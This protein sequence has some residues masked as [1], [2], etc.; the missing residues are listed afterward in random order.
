MRSSLQKCRAQ[1]ASARSPPAKPASPNPYASVSER[2]FVRSASLRAERRGRRR[3]DAER[4]RE[5]PVDVAE[6]RVHERARNGKARRQHER[7]SERAVDRHAEH[8]HEQRREQEATAVAE[9]ARD[10]AD[11]RRRP[12]RCAPVSCVRSEP[13][14]RRSASGAA[15]VNRMRSPNTRMTTSVATTSGPPGIHRVSTAPATVAGKP[16]G[17]SEAHDATVDLARACVHAAREPRRRNRRRERRRDRDDRGNADA[18]G[19]AGSRSRSRPCRT[20]PTRTRL[21]LR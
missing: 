3:R 10:E 16:I 1:C 11:D 13:A 12:S 17:Q 8:A 6:Q 19:G 2:S 4:E 20:P 21:R 5:R 15:R 14:C 18:G 9:Q 7:G